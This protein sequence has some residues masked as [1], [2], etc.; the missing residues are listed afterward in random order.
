M[1]AALKQLKLGLMEILSNGF[2]GYKQ[3]Q[4]KQQSGG[5]CNE[6]LEPCLIWGYFQLL[7]VQGSLLSL[8]NFHSSIYLIQA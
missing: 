2:M 7:E 8:H 6:C 4:F 5:G 1:V 3:C